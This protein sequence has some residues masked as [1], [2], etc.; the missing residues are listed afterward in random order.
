M[1]D[2]SSTSDGCYPLPDDLRKA[3]RTGSGP[4]IVS[5]SFRRS[6]MRAL[7]LNEYGGIDK[8]KLV[9]DEPEP[10]LGADQILIAAAA[11]SINPIDYKIR[12]GSAAARMPQT[13]PT[14]LGRDVAGIVRAVGANVTSFQPGDRVAAVAMR[15][16]A[17]LVVVPASDAALVPERVDLVDAAAYPLVCATAE[18]LVRVGAKVRAGQ[19][20][21]VTGAL[22]SVGR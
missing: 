16:Y 13:F 20:V 22:G 21:L 7:L 9:L 3:E 12:S 11:T 10:S 17:E 4:Q 19:T 2:R 1:R 14:I 6:T 8:L 18:Q 5:H 15:T